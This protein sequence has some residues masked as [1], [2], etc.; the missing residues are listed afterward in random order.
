MGA[1]TTIE[2][3]AI[4]DNFQQIVEFAK[5]YG[6]PPTKKRGILREFL[7]TKI[8]ESMYQKR[9]SS[10]IFFVGGTS[11]R[12]LRGLDRFSEDLDFDM[13]KVSFAQIEEMMMLLF[14]ELRRENITLEMY[15]NKTKKRS[16]M[17]FVLKKSLIN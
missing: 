1:K 14:H 2:M 16:F 4:I 9:I 12:F 8:L 13:G 7:Q 11:L 3:N 15:R 6:V 17:N 10:Q 5:E